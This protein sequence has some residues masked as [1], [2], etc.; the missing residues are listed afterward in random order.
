MHMLTSRDG[1]KIAYTTDGSGPSVVLVGG[2]LDDGSENA[3][4]IPALAER[5]TVVNY[6]RRG[7][8]GSGDTPPHS[9]AREIEDL[10]AVISSA[11]GSAHL[12]GASSG[13]ALALE[14]AASGVSALSIAV[15]DVPYSVTPEA[16]SAWQN[17]VARLRDALAEDDRDRAIE[18]FMSVA[19][20]PEEAI[21][22]AKSSPYWTPLLPIAHT[23][24]YD[25]A[26][27]NDGSPP[28]TRLS[29]ISQPVLLITR[30]EQDPAVS[31]IAFFTAAADAV[32]RVIESARRITVAAPT[33]VVDPEALAPV[34]TNFFD[35]P[36]AGR[37]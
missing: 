3:A 22:E 24:A 37:E 14:A 11:G 18:L 12:F 5:F 7:R 34:L 20:L 29:S 6:A 23:L 15:Y 28:R 27:L 17:Y 13:G 4:L 19:G 2:A 30:A 9:L 33:H 21:A 26:C 8:G 25:A 16:V 10:T 1:T 35:S 32:E 31:D 36:W